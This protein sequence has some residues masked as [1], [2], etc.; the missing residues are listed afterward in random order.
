MTLQ[1]GGGGGGEGGKSAAAVAHRRRPAAGG[2]QQGFSTRPTPR[3]RAGPGPHGGP[4]GPVHL[5]A[6]PFGS[7]PSESLGLAEVFSDGSSGAAW[8]SEDV[9]VGGPA[10]PF[11]MGLAAK[12]DGLCFSPAC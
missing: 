12:G 9:G 3:S 2:T 1:E 6:G 7:A 11:V 4:A 10:S 5:C 8:R